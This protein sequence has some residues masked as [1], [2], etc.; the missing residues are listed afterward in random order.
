MS[1]P[2]PG[3]E[4]LHKTCAGLSSSAMVKQEQQETQE[5]HSRPPIRL[6]T[7]ID[8]LQRQVDVDLLHQRDRLLQIVAL[9]A[10]DAQLVALDRDLDLHLAVL[11]LGD[12][13][14]ADF[15]V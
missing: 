2:P 6:V 9:L 4:W 11:D 7:K 14:L 3:T 8:I 15:A 1:Q 5:P 10:R 12:Q 13:G